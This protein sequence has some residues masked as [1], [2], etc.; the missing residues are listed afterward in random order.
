MPL[1]YTVKAE[2]WAINTQLHCS[3]YKWHIYIPYIYQLQSSHNQAVYVRSIKGNH[4]PVAYIRLK[5]N[6][7]RYLGLTYK[8]IRMLHIKSVY[9]IKG[10]V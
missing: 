4:I 9:N 2:M 6:G 3:N 10:I 1:G 7:G 8:D 5:L